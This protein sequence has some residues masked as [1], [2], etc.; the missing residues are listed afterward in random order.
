M[1][2][3]SKLYCYLFYRIRSQPSEMSCIF[4]KTRNVPIVIFIV[5]FIASSVASLLNVS[6]SLDRIVLVTFFTTSGALFVSLGYRK[7]TKRMLR[8]HRVSGSGLLKFSRF[9]LPKTTFERIVQDSVSDM[10][11]Q[12][13]E[14]LAN[15][16]VWRA[17]WIGVRDQVRILL[18]LGFEPISKAIFSVIAQFIPKK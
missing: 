4:R 10:W 17:R 5:G 8:Q 16:E 3:F 13:F 2:V 6:V 15:G 18:A 12:Q 7:M 1:R 14:A 9:L 11:V